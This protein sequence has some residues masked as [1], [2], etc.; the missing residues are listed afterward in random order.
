MNFSNAIVKFKK[1]PE[2]EKLLFFE[3]MQITLVTKLLLAILPFQKY[4]QKLGIPHKE[5]KSDPSLQALLVIDS[6]H[7]TIRRCSIYLPFKENC[8]IDAIVAKKMLKKR[9]IG[10]TIYLGA[11]LLN[12]TRL[13]AHAWLRSGSVIITGKK[14]MEKYKALEW[15]T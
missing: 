3:A 14:E 12:K 9:N 5:T 6:V 1:A 8:L 13:I 4:S 11:A 2:V 10:S 7:K 15:Y